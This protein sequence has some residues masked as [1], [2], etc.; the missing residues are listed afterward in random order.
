MPENITD[1]YVL[2]KT[3]YKESDYIVNFYT[4]DF[5]KIS[6]IARNAKKSRKRFG[7]RL[8]Q[9]LELRIKFKSGTSKINYLEDINIINSIAGISDDYDRFKWGCFILEYIENLSAKEE[10]NI[11]LYLLL[12][13]T[14]VGLNENFSI[15]D[16]LRFQYRALK[17]VGLNPELKICYKCGNDI[18]D[19]G[20]LSTRKGGLVCKDCFENI[21]I[22]IPANDVKFVLNFHGDDYK[23]I[24]NNISLLTNFTKYHTGK[25]FKS[26]KFVM[27]NNQ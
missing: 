3:V 4:R 16:V 6:V 19:F 8:E 15:N 24:L 11:P 13:K 14:L 21:K 7:G 27:E 17:C 20:Y 18:S 23:V 22:R 2:K 26:E 10:V 25:E 9:F 5:G 1:A 12:K